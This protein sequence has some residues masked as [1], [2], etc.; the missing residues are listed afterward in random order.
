MRIL[1]TGA[2]GFVGQRLCQE[3]LAEQHH[4]VGYRRP[5]TTAASAADPSADPRIEWLT[6]ELGDGAAL[7]LAMRGVDAVFHLAAAL[8]YVRA[9]RAEQW[10][11]N[12]EG[13]VRWC[14]RRSRREVGRLVH[15]SSVVAI[16]PRAD[17]LPA[18]ETTP[19][20]GARFRLGYFDSKAQAEL[21]VQQGV[22]A[23]LDAVIV[24]PSAIFGGGTSNNSSAV[25]GRVLRGGGRIAPPG[26]L[27]VVAVEDV[28]RGLR[29]AL[30]KGRCG[31]RYILGG[32]NLSYPELFRLLHSLCGQDVSVVT[33]P[34]TLWR[35]LG[36]VAAGIDRIVPLRPPLTP[37]A[38]RA[39]GGRLFYSSAKAQHE[40]GYTFEPAPS[41]L[42][43]ALALASHHHDGGHDD[44][45]VGAG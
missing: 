14:R 8:G 42:A 33:I 25:L 41:V 38:M 16:G 45:Q 22:D 18:D 20:L 44:S 5:R 9:R 39:L 26:G 17:G 31:E 19:Y 43:R 6:G 1:V 28:V 21:L 2:T 4:V 34:A 15:T 23:G 36:M 29:L 11:V 7:A 3:L 27:C 10:R 37:D 35:C 32:D 24:N 12:V 13:P 40:L 30:A